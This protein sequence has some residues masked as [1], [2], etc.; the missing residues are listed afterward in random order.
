MPGVLARIIM[1][2]M[3]REKNKKGIQP[4]MP[5]D[6]AASREAMNRVT[7]LQPCPK[8]IKKRKELIG[9][10]TCVWFESPNRFSPC[11]KY[12]YTRR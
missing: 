3:M 1:G 12:F 8:R 6:Y 2:Q 11:H 5:K 7:R 9:G 10:V 4:G